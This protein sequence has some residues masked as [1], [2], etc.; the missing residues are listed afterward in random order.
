MELVYIG[1]AIDKISCDK[2]IGASVAGNNMQ[3][4]LIKEL[5]KNLDDRLKIITVYPTASYPTEKNIL[6]RKKRIKINENIYSTLVSFINIPFIKEFTQCICVTWEV[7]KTIRKNKRCKILTFNARPSVSI[8][9]IF[10]KKFYNIELICLLADP[11]VD[12]VNRKGL[13]KISKDIFWKIIEFAITKYDKIIALNKEAIHIYAKDKQHIIIDGAIDGCYIDKIET[14]QNKNNSA[15]V[16][17]FSGA[18]TEY[19][20]IKELLE[21]M[22]YVRDEKIELHIY[23]DGNLKNYVEEKSKL[24]TN[25]FY[26]GI[27]TNEEMKKIQQ[28]SNLLINPRRVD[29]LIS[30]VTFPSK[31]IEYM[32]SG[33]PV[34]ST[35]LNGLT[36]DYIENIYIIRELSPKKLAE[37][38]ERVL[39]ISYEELEEKAKNAKKFILKRK[40]WEVQGKKIYDFIK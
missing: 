33:T 1:Y 15:K 24:N 30:R 37:D 20:G 18:L 22:K 19:N 26:K 16:I 8:P 14:V 9:V 35:N 12:I 11:P 3:L 23:G 6:F 7:Y 2:Q 34:L 38:I 25:I 5:Y 27:V 36:K 17:V 4:G 21:S 29:D 32:L 28:V 10:L 31:I 40:T 13:D 39:N